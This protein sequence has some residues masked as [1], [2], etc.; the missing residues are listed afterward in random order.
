MRVT[1]PFRRTRPAPG[2]RVAV[3]LALVVLLSACI[4]HPFN[5]RSGAPPEATPQARIAEVARATAWALSVPEARASVLGSM[6]A[7]PRV[8]HSLVLQDYLADVAAGVLLDR[9]ADAMGVAAS[10]Y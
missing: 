7:S 6:R 10:E 9:S 3:P 2:P 1:S 4:E 8:D 5:P